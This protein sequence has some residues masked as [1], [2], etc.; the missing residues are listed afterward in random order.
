[1]IIE[2]MCTGFAKWRESTTT[3]PSGKHLGIYKSLINARRF[4]IRT[5]KEKLQDTETSKTNTTMSLADQFLH[6]Q[7][8]LIMLAIK[9]CHRYERWKVVHNF[10]LEKIPGLP[11]IDK[12]RII[13]IYEPG[14]SI[15]HKYYITHKLNN[16]AS[17]EKTIP[18]E[19]AGGR[20]GRSA[21]EV[22]ASRS[23]MYE[24]VRLQ[25]L[26]GAVLYNDANT[27]YDRIIENIRNLTLLKEGLPPEIAK[28][29]A[30]T[31]SQM[32]YHIKHRFGIGTKHHSH[33]ME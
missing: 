14:W 8:L 20:P 22:A 28:L 21:I 29:H 10:L 31:I 26:N 2:S 23:L 11:W 17:K 5:D 27:C 25:R 30:H 15:I 33:Y 12:L 24:S 6:I 18:I 19:Q 4:I 9:Q 13:H 16:I 7:F 32:Q 3:S 1:M